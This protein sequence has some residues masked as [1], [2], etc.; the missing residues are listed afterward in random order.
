MRRNLTKEERLKRR[1]D[2]DKVFTIGKRKSG[3][4][5]RLIY[6][7]NGYEFNRYAV[8]PVRKYGTAVERNRAKRICRELFRTFKDR[9]QSCFDIIL[10]VYPEK[11]TFKGRAEE[12]SS[13]L[14]KAGLLIRET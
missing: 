11:D 1:S 5:V 7:K 3:S 8:C 14:R 6:V 4:G 12:Y 13:L 10:V 2:F 9:V